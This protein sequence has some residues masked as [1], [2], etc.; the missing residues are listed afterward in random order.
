MI[1]SVNISGK[2]LLDDSLINDVDEALIK[3]GLSAS[4]LKL[5]VTES[6]AMENAEQTIEIF[7][8][9]KELGVRLSIDD[10]GTGY[11]SLNYLHRLPF[12]TLKID[13]SFVNGI[14]EDGEDSEVLQTIILLA[15]NLKMGV[16]AEG[17]ETVQQL[18]LLRNLRCEYGQGYLMS[19]PLPK[20]EIEKAL[21]QNRDWFSFLK[22]ETEKKIPKTSIYEEN[23]RVFN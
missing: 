15:K 10:F 20:E 17:I 22:K 5:E 21:R 2:H 14:G 4:S 8:E 16:I 3:S 12:D 23:P 13:R 6:I 18:S 7:T 19:K 11:S 9:L 1:V